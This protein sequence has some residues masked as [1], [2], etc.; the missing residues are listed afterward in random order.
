MLNTTRADKIVLGYS[1][2]KLMQ[3][4][5]VKRKL[6]NQDAFYGSYANKAWSFTHGIQ[7]L[8]FIWKIIEDFLKHGL[9]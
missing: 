1:A 4:K 5:G 8:N 6:R 2:V 9:S 7:V 3:R